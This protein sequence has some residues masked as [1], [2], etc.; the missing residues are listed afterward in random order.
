MTE[1]I[2]I[3]SGCSNPFY[4]SD[5]VNTD[6]R[7]LCGSC[8]T[9][10]GPE[11]WDD[12]EP[13][14]EPAAGG[15]WTEGKEV[16]LLA[17][18]VGILDPSVLDVDN[19]P[20]AADVW[21]DPAYRESENTGG[22]AAVDKFRAPGANKYSSPAPDED[23][24]T[25]RNQPVVEGGR[26]ASESFTPEDG[27]ES[28]GY[29]GDTNY[30]T[31]GYTTD[32]NFE[33]GKYGSDPGYD[34]GTYGTDG[35][36]TTDPGYDSGGYSSDPNYDSGGYSS[37]PGYES[38]KYGSDPGYDSGTYASSG[39]SSGGIDSFQDPGYD[40]GGTDGYHAGGSQHAMDEYDETSR[41]QA[42]SQYAEH[43][44]AH[45]VAVDGHES[46]GSQQN[47]SATTKAW[48][49][50]LDS[51]ELAGGDASGSQG[52]AA[53]SG[54]RGSADSWGKPAVSTMDESWSGQS[55]GAS[56]EASW[57]TQ[58]GASASAQGQ[59]AV[60]LRE[61]KEAEQAQARKK[62]M[63][64]EMRG[65]VLKALFVFVL[66]GGLFAGAWWGIREYQPRYNRSDLSTW[67]RD[68][69]REVAG[70]QTASDLY[71]VWE[72]AELLPLHKD[73]MRIQIQ[74]RNLGD[75]TVEVGPARF[76]VQ[77]SGQGTSM[78]IPDVARMVSNLPSL[79]DPAFEWGPLPPHTTREGWIFVLV[80][81]ST[82]T[83]VTLDGIELNR[84]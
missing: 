1:E 37:D 60:A 12:D 25:A 6:G 22:L 42:E 81:N 20:D 39:A 10:V 16:G 30:D 29:A 50:I 71:A 76:N 35:N 13:A 19:N 67:T 79:L 59:T 83:G 34:S 17:K 61:A 36:Y 28:G 23:V 7:F 72:R 66:V 40:S 82:V 77:L 32:T 11:Q 73:K 63:A 75:S 27:F 31:D 54:S 64:P 51:G 14:A 38:G 47:I 18:K 58:S 78:P 56:G 57:G 53:E 68:T 69:D 65:A 24:E 84:Q 62:A 2:D 9:Q 55:S 74:V 41:V 4:L 80:G 21:E 15:S 48:D 33:S 45:D 43:A 70:S 46:T 44:S 3:C 5:M 49:D 52:W 26:R 8:A